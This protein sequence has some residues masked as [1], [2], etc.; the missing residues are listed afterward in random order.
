MNAPHPRPAPLQVLLALNGVDFEASANNI[1]Y[2]YYFH[3]THRLVPSGGPSI[4]GTRV[5][6][7]GVGF[8]R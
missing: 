1:S 6:V 3:N 5:S 2:I 7:V 4:G 8:G